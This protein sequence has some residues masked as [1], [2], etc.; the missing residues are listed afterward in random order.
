MKRHDQTIV[1]IQIQMSFDTSSVVL[2]ELLSQT[3]VKAGLST[4]RDVRKEMEAKK[5]KE[6]E[7]FSKVRCNL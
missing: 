2:V 5:R 4:G 7:M 1:L 3:G 6:E